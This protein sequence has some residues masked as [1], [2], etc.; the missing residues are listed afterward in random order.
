MSYHA[1]LNELRHKRGNAIDQAST[2]LNAATAAKRDLTPEENVKFDAFHKEADEIRASIERIERQVSAEAQL[3]EPGE[4]RAGKSTGSPETANGENPGYRGAFNAYLRKAMLSP[5]LESRTAMSVGTGS[6]GGYTVPTHLA[7]DIE[8]ALKAFGGMRA[9]GAEIIPTADGSPMLLPSANDV[10]NVGFIVSENTTIS[11]ATPATFGQV[12]LPV[13]MYSSGIVLI[14]NQLLQDSA[15]DMDS[16]IRNLIQ[17]RIGR[18]QNSHFTTGDASSK[19]QGVVPVATTGVT[20]AAVAAVTTDELYDLKGS[21]DPAY[22]ANGKWMFSNT[23]LASI[24]KLKGTT[25]YSLWQPGLAS[26]APDRIDG[27]P[28][29]INT[30]MASLGAGNTAILYGDFSKYKI[31][32]VRDGITVLRLNERYADVGQVAF[33]ALMRSGGTLVDAGTH[34]VKAYVCAAS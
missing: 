32:D 13:Y 8:V 12:S 14:S 20:G 2:I 1:Q 34:P 19:P 21:V 31:R 29:I 15:Y 28:Y 18:I 6:T 11:T 23:T 4:I 5:E 33:V 25:G 9:S 17:T 26:G 22:A 30:D 16:F 3:N 7:A 24:K 27:D 10:S